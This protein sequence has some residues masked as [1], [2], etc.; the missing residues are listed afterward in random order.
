MRKLLLPTLCGLALT[1]SALP[2]FAGNKDRSGQAGATQLLINPWAKST[3]VFGLDGSHISGLE[4]MKVNIGGLARGH[5]TE[6]GAAYSQYLTKTGISI[7]DAG[8]AQKLGNIGT[9]G[10]N[11]FSM[12]FGE[13]PIVN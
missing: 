11:I 1:V 2:A 12:N 5:K 13:I 8:F 4:A 6:L 9:L 10:V 7:V 3:G